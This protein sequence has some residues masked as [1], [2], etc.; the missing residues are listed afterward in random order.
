MLILMFSHGH[1]CE[2]HDVE[3]DKLLRALTASDLNKPNLEDMMEWCSV[4]PDY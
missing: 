4:R 3:F 2:Y 1:A